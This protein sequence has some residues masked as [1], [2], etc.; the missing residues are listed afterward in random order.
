M[1]VSV[2]YLSK[3]ERQNLHEYRYSRFSDNPYCMDL[4][5]DFIEENFRILPV[6]SPGE[7]ICFLPRFVAIGGT[8]LED[9]SVWVSLHGREHEFDLPTV[10]GMYPAWRKY[11]VQNRG[12]D[13][14]RA[15]NL[16]LQ[17]CRNYIRDKGNPE[18]DD[19]VREAEESWLRE[20]RRERARAAKRE[21]LRDFMRD[22]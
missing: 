18:W 4:L 8:A 14:G 16:I 12:S 6:E 11:H 13:I 22:F 17:A 9:T 15:K 1:P 21:F 19:M 20:R 3:E 7:T 10:P 5:L 2:P